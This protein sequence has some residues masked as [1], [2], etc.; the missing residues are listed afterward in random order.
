VCVAG[1]VAARVFQLH[2]FALKMT[3]TIE[4]Q[5][6]EFSVLILHV[7]LTNSMLPH[8]HLVSLIHLVSSLWHAKP[9][10]TIPCFT[11]I[12]PLTVSAHSSFN[13]Q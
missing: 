9:C 8:H 5:G 4:H 1:G 12:P 7:V 3:L 2:K 10:K 11:S 6:T 13:A